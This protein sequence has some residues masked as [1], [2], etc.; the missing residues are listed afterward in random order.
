MWTC[1]DIHLTS[2]GLDIL[3]FAPRYLGEGFWKIEE[4]REEFWMCKAPPKLFWEKYFRRKTNFRI[5][6]KLNLCTS[7]YVK[8]LLLV[9]SPTSSPGTPYYSLEISSTSHILRF[10]LRIH[11]LP[12]RSIWSCFNI[13]LRWNLDFP[14]GRLWVDDEGECFAPSIFY[15]T[16]IYFGHNH[17]LV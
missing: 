5:S 1:M 2:Q 11:I 9:R 4:F 16:L 15:E 8:R 12:E 3:P 14:F 6:I 13:I 7:N 10:G 17:Y